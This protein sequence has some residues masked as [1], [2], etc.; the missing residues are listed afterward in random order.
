ML[1]YGFILIG[2]LLVVSVWPWKKVNFE[3]SFNAD[4]IGDDV[5]KYL[6]LTEGENKFL[7]PWARKKII[8]HGK[9]KTTKTA[10]SM[11]YIHG[12]SASLA[13]TRPVPDMVAKKLGAN[14]YFARLSG[15]GSRDPLALGR[16]SGKHW[17]GDVEEAVEIGL[18]IGDQVLIMATSFGAV[19]VSEYLSKNNLNKRIIGTVFVSP[20]YGLNWRVQ[21]FRYPIWS[22][23]LYPTIFGKLRVATSQTEEESK[24]WSQVYPIEAIENLAL[25]V[26]K[27]WRSNFRNIKS[28]KLI[29]FCEKDRWISLF[30]IREMPKRWGGGA[31]L[32]PIEVPSQTDNN[33]YHVIMGDIKSPTQNEKG[34]QI[35]LDWLSKNFKLTQHF[36]N[37]K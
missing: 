34:A 10:I 12:F 26:D 1:F 4:D 33:N 35:I 13:E 21:L 11:V 37:K 15:H 8:W 27:I 19:L 36:G 5:T 31:S 2:V 14:L 23:F 7:H 24:W 22:K 16:C 6:R 9:K 32:K 28:P 3:G 30:R 20:C 17:Y 29:I 18:R 25:S